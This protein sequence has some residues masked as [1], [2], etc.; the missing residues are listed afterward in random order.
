MIDLSWRPARQ[1]RFDGEVY[2]GSAGEL[3][4]SD[5]EQAQ[6]RER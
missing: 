6:D 5:R 2:E 1:E 3:V 4:N